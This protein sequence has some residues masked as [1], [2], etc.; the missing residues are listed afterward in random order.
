MISF[1]AGMVKVLVVF[2]IAYVT[3]ATLGTPLAEAVIPPFIGMVLMD[4][5]IIIGKVS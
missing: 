1:I 3:H 5:S 4:L 2:G